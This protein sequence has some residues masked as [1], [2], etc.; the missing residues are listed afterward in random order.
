MV[1][2][3][4]PALAIAGSVAGGWLANRGNKE[5]AVKARQ[6]QRAMRATAYQD[7]V[8]DLRAAGLNPALAYGRGATSAPSG[9]MATQDDILGGAVSSGIQAAMVKKQ[10]KLLDAQ[11]LQAQNLG[12]KTMHEANIA[13]LEEHGKSARWSYYFTP[14]GTPKG[15]LRELLQREHEGSM[16]Q[17]GKS[18][19]DLELA[20]F[21][22]PERQAVAALFE[23]LG[24]EGKGAQLL[25]P[26][27]LQ[28]LRR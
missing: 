2:W 5:E 26:L 25:M 8:A 9:P 14:Q 7:T 27:I 23:Q 13:R 24:K 21:S 17:S 10:M 18:V 4:G 20:R 19:A 11:T 15:P 12:R 1:M 22:I 16:A 28:L 6:H 3:I